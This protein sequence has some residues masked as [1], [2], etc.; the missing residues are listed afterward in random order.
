VQSG[1]RIQVF[2]HLRAVDLLEQLGTIL[3]I[4]GIA[5]HRRQPVGRHGHEACHRQPS[6]DVLD[7][8]I[9]AAILVNH[10]DRGELAARRG[11]PHQIAVDMAG[12]V[13][14][15]HCELFRLEA[16]V[17]LRHLYRPSVIGPEHLDQG[18]RGHGRGGEFLRA[19]QEFAPADAAMHIGIQQ[20]E[21]FLRKVGG[22]FASAGVQISLP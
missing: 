14:G 22:I 15:G 10:D 7:V 12:A 18:R 6:R 8:G 19:C 5:A 2:G 20:V 3:V 13:G 11:G 16:I 1:R 4:A 17:I 21:K 9:E